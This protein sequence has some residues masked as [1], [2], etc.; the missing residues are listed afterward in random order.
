MFSY[1]SLLLVLGGLLGIFEAVFPTTGIRAPGFGGGLGFRDSELYA[2][3]L[4]LCLICHIRNEF[5]I[6]RRRCLGTLKVR[7]ML[8][9][10]SLV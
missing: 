3:W 5:S 1:F 4:Q 8:C 7:S 6:V 9:G 2:L 10:C